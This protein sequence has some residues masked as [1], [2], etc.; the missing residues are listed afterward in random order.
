M[1]ISNFLLVAIFFSVFPV[2]AQINGLFGPDSTYPSQSYYFDW[3]SSQYEGTTEDQAMA[4]LEFF[5]YLHDEYGMT[6]DIYSLDVGNIDDGPY[7]AGV[8]RLI[9]Y[10]YGNLES[11]EFRKQFPNGFGPL[12]DKAAEFGCRLGIWLGPGGFIGTEAEKQLRK[13][14]MVALCRDHNFKLFKMDAVAGQF[15]Q[16][17]TDWMMETI[18]ECRKYAPDLIISSHRV[19]F[20]KVTPYITHDLWAGEETYVDVFINNQQ[21]ATHHREGSLQ[22]G[23]T[24]G[25][26]R[27]YEDHGVCLSSCMD[28]WEDELILQAFN[29]SLIMAPQIYGNPWLLSDEELPKLAR[30]FN[31][32]RKYRDI[33]IEGVVLPED[34]YGPVAVSRGNEEMRFITL[35]NLT[36][37]PKVYQ[38]DLDESIGL[39]KSKRLQVMQYH[40]TEKY[41]GDYRWGE[42]AEVYVLPFGTCLVQVSA[43]DIDDVY[44]EGCDYYVT[45]AREGE[46]VEL[47]LLGWPGETKKVK[48][49]GKKETIHFPERDEMTWF[50]KKLSDHFEQVE[51]PDESEALYEA[52]CFANDNNALEV[53]SLLR[54]GVTGI[55]EVQACRDYFFSKPMFVNRGIWDQQL[56]DADVET[57]FIAR[58]ENK[59]LRINLGSVTQLDEMIIR[60]RPRQ[61]YDLNPE[62]NR[63]GDEAFAEVSDDLVHWHKARLSKDGMGTIARI[64]SLPVSGVQYIRIHQPPRR[65]AEVEG[66]RNG[67]QLDRSN[68]SASNLFN[69]YAGNE[70]K[71]VWK[72]SYQVPD[73]EV[74]DNSYL[75][76]ALNGHHGNEGAWVAMKVDGKLIGAYDRAVSFP[77]NTWEYYNVEVENDYTYYL[78][79]EE[80]FRGKQIEVF[81][82]VM[83]NG[84]NEFTPELWQSAY[85]IPFEKIPFTI[86]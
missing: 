82:L 28:N 3:I 61:E 69:A 8:G 78:P 17:Q 62:M 35:R 57:F 21:T 59:P 38:I 81:V 23:L 80:D 42:Q 64:D 7:T 2:Q 65:I 84:S 18:R 11:K 68:W 83:K 13:E 86:E 74:P 66:Y 45:R 52:T 9:P 48:I 72:T 12:A 31:L 47:E 10:H 14:M 43:E 55:P 60:I 56:F 6:L 50:H 53:R 37:K 27:M 44:V 51:I 34:Q 79:F 49:N 63:F 33:L 40:P 76:V 4:Q 1:K 77:S 46:P 22:R 25:M 41:L 67:R 39:N 19:D 20:G 26:S 70:A 85:P 29:R 54:S 30:I 75:A 5:K 32:H 15:D 24:P 71:V 36:W 16:S 73:L 58:L